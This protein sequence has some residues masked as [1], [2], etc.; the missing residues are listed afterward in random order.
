VAALEENNFVGSK[1]ITPANLL[2]G[3]SYSVDLG[4]GE[5]EKV[6]EEINLSYGDTIESTAKFERE[7][8]IAEEIE[9]LKGTSKNLGN[10]V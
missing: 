4:S 10:Q 3:F 7:I 1:T 8:Q 9:D 6:L 2:P 5:N